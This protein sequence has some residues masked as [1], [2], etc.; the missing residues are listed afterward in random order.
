MRMTPEERAGWDR[1]GYLVRRSVFS[2]GEVAELRDAAEEIAAGVKERAT[3]VGAGP[4]ALMADGHRIQFSS[5]AAIQWE[6]REGSQE[7][8]LVEP[9]D[10]LHPLVARSAGPD[11]DSQIVVSDGRGAVVDGQRRP[12]HSELR[13][14]KPLR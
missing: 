7:I 10:H 12:H 3:R 5:H 11:R 8:R 4:E 6:W 9:C 13:L 1:D 2:P 14:A